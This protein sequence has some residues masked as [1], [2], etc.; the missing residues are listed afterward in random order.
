MFKF[1]YEVENYTLLLLYLFSA[2]DIGTDYLPVY[3]T[4]N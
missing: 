2:V 1:E 3:T 4:N